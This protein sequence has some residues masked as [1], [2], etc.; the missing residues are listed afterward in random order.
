[1]AGGYT[2]PSRRDVPVPRGVGLISAEDAVK[3]AM[4]LDYI[5][6]R[7]EKE[8]IIDRFTAIMTGR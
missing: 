8:E 1:V 4:C 6:L 3:R 2:L 5:K 7:S